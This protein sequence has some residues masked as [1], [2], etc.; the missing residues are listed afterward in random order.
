MTS[1]LLAD[2]GG[3]QARFALLSGSTVGPVYAV[4]VGMH[5]DATQAIR[6]FL[7]TTTEAAKIDR[8][9]VAAAGPVSGGRCKLTNTNWT[10]DTAE[11][12]KAF[13]L[14]TVK[15]V[16]DLEALAWSLPHLVSADCAQIGHGHSVTAEP[17]A[18]IS[19]GTGL[20]MA[21]FLPNG[22]G[23]AL[24][25]EGGHATLAATG[26]QEA[27]LITLLQKRHSHVSAERVLSG[28]GLV[29]LYDALAEQAGLTVEPP[30][31]AQI[32][33]AAMEGS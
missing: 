29:N 9:V 6:H 21:C 30:T 16:N 27:V 1:C 3:T 20:G 10:L 28:Q 8:A 4:Q 23:R 5:A 33:R 24:A 11:L 17:M 13:G 31:P 7:S 12:R 32:T 19:P 22:L 2:I 18:V 14:S 26:P 15:F 25:S